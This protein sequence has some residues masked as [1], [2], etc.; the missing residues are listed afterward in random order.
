M[1]GELPLDWSALVP[2]VLHPLKVEIIEAMCWIGRSLSATELT[3]I[4]DKPNQISQ[5]A[6]HMKTLKKLG[7]IEMTRWEPVRGTK[8]N[9]YF[10]TKQM[11][12][13]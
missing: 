7:V 6:Y 13:K 4:L 8:E 5:I 1:G 12:G 9:F 3:R 10:L 11:L 2:H